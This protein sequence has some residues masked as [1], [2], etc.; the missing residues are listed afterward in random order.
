M[1]GT[2]HG[3]E[4][5]RHRTLAPPQSRLIADPSNRGQ[6]ACPVGSCYSGH[7]NQNHQRNCSASEHPVTHGRQMEET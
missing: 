3:M 7:A 6:I 4:N 1:S 5:R 2:R